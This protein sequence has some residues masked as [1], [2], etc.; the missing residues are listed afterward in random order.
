[1]KIQKTMPFY[2]QTADFTPWPTFCRN[3]FKQRPMT[4]KKQ[5]QKQDERNSVPENENNRIDN[6][7]GVDK[8]PGEE[9]GKNEKVTTMDLKGKKVDADPEKESDQPVQQNQS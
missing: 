3:F 9:A 4:D 1:M 6:G 8:A 2:I 7:E 5:T